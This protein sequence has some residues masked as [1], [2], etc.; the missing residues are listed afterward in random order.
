MSD[1]RD[2]ITEALAPLGPDAQQ[3]EQA[4]WAAIQGDESE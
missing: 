4:V 2:R 1:L 3:F